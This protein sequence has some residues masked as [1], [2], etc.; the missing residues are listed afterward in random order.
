M[1]NGKYEPAYLT[2]QAIRSKAA[3]LLKRGSML[4]DV[5]VKVEELVEFV[6][7]INIVPTPGLHEQLGIDGFTSGDCKD[8]LVEEAVFL[9]SPNRLRFTLA[10]ELG[11]R[12][13]HYSFY[14][15]KSYYGIKGWREYL[16]NFSQDAHKRFEWQANAFAAELLMPVNTL[17]PEAF[18]LAS[19]YK[20]GKDDQFQWTMVAATLADRFQVS[21]S[22][23]QIRIEVLR[24]R[25][26]A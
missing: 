2:E 5:P 18:R 4:D 14:E 20:A 9:E 26:R 19:E 24:L 11:H 10:H 23:M 1:A 17:E 21:Q 13:L 22:A 6:L 7:G 15:G 8:I 3:D 25:D 16:A 12:E